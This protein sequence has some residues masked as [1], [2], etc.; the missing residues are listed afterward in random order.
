[1]HILNFSF[2]VAVGFSVALQEFIEAEKKLYP[3]KK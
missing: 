2:E 1:M 3:T